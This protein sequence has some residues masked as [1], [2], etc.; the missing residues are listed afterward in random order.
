MPTAI[1][2]DFRVKKG[3]EA[4]SLKIG[5]QEVTSLLDS[6]SVSTVVRS[7]TVAK[8]IMNDGGA[9]LID[10]L[11]IGNIELSLLRKK[12]TMIPQDPTLFA[13]PL[14]YSLDP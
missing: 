3:V 11:N 13:G 10:S 1:K 8:Q 12:I 5:T 2:K 14:R 7:P 6:S 9:I 4:P